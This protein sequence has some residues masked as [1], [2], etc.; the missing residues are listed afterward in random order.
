MSNESIKISDGM[1]SGLLERALMRHVYYQGPEFMMPTFTPAG[2]WECD[3]WAVTQA[4]YAVEY[5][6]KVSRGDFRRD[7]KK[8]KSF[9][10]RNEKGQALSAWEELNKLTM[11]A[12]KDGRC[13]NRFY[14]VMP[15]GMIELAELPANCGLITFGEYAATDSRSHCFSQY[16]KVVK[17]A[18]LLHNVKPDPTLVQ[19]GMVSAYHRF[20]RGVMA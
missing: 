15:A 16:G 1:R 20:I 9:R 12:A 18:P 5:E 4:G 2:W 14:Y 7:A 10:R 3:V 19:Q 17:R 6:I 11:I 13:Q 8:C